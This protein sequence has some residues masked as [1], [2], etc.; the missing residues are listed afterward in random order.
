MGVEISEGKNPK[1]QFLDRKKGLQ[2]RTTPWEVPTPA[3]GEESV[4][5]S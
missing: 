3:F 5:G 2:K 4:A 1:L